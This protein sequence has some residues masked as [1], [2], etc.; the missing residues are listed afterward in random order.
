MAPHPGQGGVDQGETLRRGGLI[1]IDLSQPL[2]LLLTARVPSPDQGKEPVV[3]LF[4]NP[5]S[6]STRKL[7]FK[8]LVKTTNSHLRL[9]TSLLL[10]PFATLLL[11]SFTLSLLCI[12][13]TPSSTH[14]LISYLYKASNS[15]PRKHSLTSRLHSMRPGLS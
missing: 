2:P 13:T 14:P 15:F 3:V 6:S 10:Y 1:R 7:D 5:S 12:F 9:I 8:N 11:R 4:F